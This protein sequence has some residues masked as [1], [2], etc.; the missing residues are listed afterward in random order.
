VEVR[1]E[2]GKESQGSFHLLINRIGLTQWFRQKYREFQEAIGIKPK[3]KL[4]VGKS[5]GIRR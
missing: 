1:F 2:R 3:Q 5:K 4:E